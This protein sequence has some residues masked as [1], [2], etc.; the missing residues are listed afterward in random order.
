MLRALSA[1]YQRIKAWPEALRQWRIATRT[2]RAVDLKEGEP[3]DLLFLHERGFVRARATGQS[4]AQISAEV[5]NLIN[6]P[7]IVVIKP[8]TYF[9]ARGNYQNMVTRREYTVTLYPCATQNVSIDAT[10][11]NAGL[12]I[13]GEKDRFYGVRRVSDDLARFLDAAQGVDPITIQAGVWALS[14][15]YSA[16]DILNHLVIRDQHGNTRRAVSDDNIEQARRI[17]NTL[18]IQHRL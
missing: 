15:N 7:L 2:A 10:C 5:E 3:Y 13:P 4:I 6:K 18:G 12:P 1:V 11:I 8:G 17:L 14:D 16:D 9:V